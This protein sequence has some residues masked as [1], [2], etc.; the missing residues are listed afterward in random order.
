MNESRSN[1]RV[2]RFDELT[3]RGNVGE[4]RHGFLRLTP[5]YSVHLVRNL[6]S[7]SSAGG[8]VL[9]PFCGTGT[10]ALSCAELGI[11]CTT[12]DLNPF[13]V[14]FARAKVARYTESDIS[15][16]ESLVTKMTRAARARAGESIVPPIHRIDRWWDG[17][18]LAALGRARAVASRATADVPQKAQD[19]AAVAFCRAVIERANVSFGHQSMS[20]KK[21]ARKG[22][23]A[24]SDGKAAAEVGASLERAFA[25]VVDALERPLSRSKRRVLSGDSRSISEVVG[26]ERFARVVTSPPYPNRMSYVRELRPYMYWL[27]YLS[28]RRDA[29]ELDWSAIG[30][31][32]GAATSRLGSWRPDP[33]VEVPF[34][35]LRGIV[36]R[37]D[38]HEPLLA[39]YVERYFEDMTHHTRSLSRVVSPG[40][41]VQYV[42]GNS[43]FYDVLVPVQ[44]IYA[45][46]FERAG[47]VKTKIAVLRKR[48]SKREL[49][50][51]L[52]EAE[53]PGRLR[54]RR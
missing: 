10:T 23:G 2:G 26:D 25:T 50:E 28:E 53:M 4:T 20:F 32:W 17:P 19:L 24:R 48:T 31:T 52:V 5:A 9:D 38:R 47:F 41:R 22:N 15:N 33:H 51:Y 30:G 8:T 54:S 43:K 36:R 40:G 49:F 13:L 12:I 11:D 34:D 7:Q 14:W 6:L 35:G 16:A 45:S 18:V 39:R 21:G 42:V 46:L 29:G 3:F 44:D 1:G 37:I 27:G